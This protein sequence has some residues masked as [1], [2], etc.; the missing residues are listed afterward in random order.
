MQPRLSLKL[1]I[2][3]PQIPECWN[4][5]YDPPHPVSRFLFSNHRAD[6]MLSKRPPAQH[7]EKCRTVKRY[8]G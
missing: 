4:Y 7:M 3:L 5:R 1:M 6:K 8:F 2:L